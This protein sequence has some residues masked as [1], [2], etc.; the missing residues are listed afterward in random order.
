MNNYGLTPDLA[1][2]FAAQFD[3]PTPIQAAV[4]PLLSEGTSIFG[5]APTGTGKTLA[6]L[7]PL[8]D[9]VAGKGTQILIVSPSQELAMQTTHVARDWAAKK[10]L[11]VAN[12]IGGANGRRQADKLKEKPAIVVG[13]IG[14]ILTMLESGA[15]KLDQLKALV[16]DEADALL[17]SERDAEWRSLAS[18]VPRDV[19]LGLFSATDGVDMAKVQ[20]TFGIAPQLVSVGQD[21]PKAIA[22]TYQFADE[23]AKAK[24]LGQIARRQKALVFFNQAS[25]LE[26]MEATLKH[27]H[28][29]VAT[30]GSYDKRQTQRANALER[31][32]KGDV[33]LL[34]VTDV[35]A[36]G[37][38][39]VDLPLV[40]NAQIPRDLKTYVHRSG[41][42]GRVGK[43]GRVL[44]LGNDHDIRDLKRL[45][46]GVVAL[47]KAVFTPEKSPAVVTKPQAT[48]RAKQQPQTFKADAKTAAKQTD[49]HQQTSNQVVKQRT[50]KT[51]QTTEPTKAQRAK[52]KKKHQKNKGMRRKRAAQN[53]STTD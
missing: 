20:G 28:V 3:A 10:Q 45:T 40:I 32:R 50:N 46:E 4:W 39:I 30:I 22:H 48:Q 49:D 31:F 6:F 15:L 29:R 37:L 8:L 42:T 44:S 52:A 16:I 1:D 5:L 11:K 13:T 33:H 24:I 35:A 21:V 36:R 38:D 7:L 25:A 14:R 17:D 18:Y 51:V 43:A 34:L 27:N 53:T 19:Q 12:L 9:R 47:E 41:R 2:A 23:K 26:R